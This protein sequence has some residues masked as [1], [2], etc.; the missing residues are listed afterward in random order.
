[1]NQ[2]LRFHMAA[3]HIMSA[4]VSLS[5]IWTIDWQTYSFSYRHQTLPDYSRYCLL[6]IAHMVQKLHASLKLIRS[7]RSL[8]CMP[9]WSS[10]SLIYCLLFVVSITIP[11]ICHSF[12]QPIRAEGLEIFLDSLFINDRTKRK[13]LR[14]HITLSNWTFSISDNCFHVGW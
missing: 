7:P 8:S 3:A 10:E 9:E 14:K 1:M 2:F 12:L 4:M 6:L 13:I 11:N 5:L